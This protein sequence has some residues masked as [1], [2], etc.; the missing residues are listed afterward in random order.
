MHREEGDPDYYNGKAIG[1][2]LDSKS[3]FKDQHQDGATTPL[4]TA[5][6]WVWAIPSTHL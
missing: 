2:R 3:A 1:D 5:P 6:I 4:W